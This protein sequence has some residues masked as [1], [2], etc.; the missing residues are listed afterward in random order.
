MSSYENGGW[1]KPGWIT[2]RNSSGRPEPV[3]PPQPD[4]GRIDQLERELG[5]G[6][7]PPEPERGIREDRTVC[8]IKSCDGDTTELR[9]W[10]GRLIRRI[11]E[12]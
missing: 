5:I 11:H 1:L 3:V 2:H 8:L 9:T 7:P 6:D 4:Y 12:H 10:Q